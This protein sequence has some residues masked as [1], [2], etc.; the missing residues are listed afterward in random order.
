[1]ESLIDLEKIEREGNETFIRKGIFN[2]RDDFIA[3]IIRP[4]ECK[5]SLCLAF[6]KSLYDINKDAFIIPNAK[7]S[8]AKGLWI[9][10]EKEMRNIPKNIAKD[11]IDVEG[12]QVDDLSI[13]KYIMIVTF[14]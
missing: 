9:I 7:L 11:I 6:Y 14:I 10:K 13:W 12:F 4:G 2:S 8:F 3:F 5:I 1:M